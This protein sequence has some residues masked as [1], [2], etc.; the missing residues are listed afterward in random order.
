MR[1]I[2]SINSRFTRALVFSAGV[3]LAALAG[4]WSSQRPIKTKTAE[5]WQLHGAISLPNPPPA[6]DLLKQPLNKP[7]N[8]L[9]V[10]E[11]ADLIFRSLPPISNKKEPPS[12]PKEAAVHLAD[13]GFGPNEAA[14][15][16][17]PGPVRT[18]LIRDQQAFE[19]ITPAQENNATA[20]ALVPNPLS[21]AQRA[22][23]RRQFESLAEVGRDW[24]GKYLDHKATI[25]THD[26]LSFM[27]A[28]HYWF[29]RMQDKVYLMPDSRATL[30]DLR[31]E[32]ERWVKEFEPTA[33]DPKLSLDDKKQRLKG[34]IR[35]KAV[36]DPDAT[37]LVSTLREV[38]INGRRISINAGGQQCVTR[39][40]LAIGLILRFPNI[41]G[42]HNRLLFSRYGNDNNVVVNNPD[43]DDVAIYNTK[44]QQVL[45]GDYSTWMP[46]SAVR[47]NLLDPMY[48]V[49][50]LV[51][52]GSTS[53]FMF[54]ESEV[55]QGKNNAKAVVPGE[56]DPNPPFGG[57]ASRNT[58]YQGGKPVVLSRQTSFSDAGSLQPGSPAIWLGTA[59]SGRPGSAVKP[60]ALPHAVEGRALLQQLTTEAKRI[61]AQRFQ[62]EAEEKAAA[63]RL[64]KLD[65]VLTSEFSDR[66]KD[67]HWAL[68]HKWRVHFPLELCNLGL[69]G[70]AKSEVEDYIFRRYRSDPWQRLFAF[71]FFNRDAEGLLT[72]SPAASPSVDFLKRLYDTYQTPNNQW[73]GKP[74]ADYLTLDLS[75]ILPLQPERI[76][77]NLTN[78][79]KE[80][81]ELIDKAQAL[82]NDQ[83]I[84]QQLLIKFKEFSQLFFVPDS[85]FRLPPE[86]ALVL[87]KTMADNTAFYDRLRSG[88][89]ILEAVALD[90]AEPLNYD[91][92]LRHKDAVQRLEKIDWLPKEHKDAIRLVLAPTRSVDHSITPDTITYLFTAL[93]MDIGKVALLLDQE[94]GKHAKTSRAISQE[95][96][97]SMTAPATPENKRELLNKVKA[98]FAVQW[99]Y[100]KIIDLKDRVLN[101]NDNSSILQPLPGLNRAEFVPLANLIIESFDY[102][103]RLY[104]GY[105]EQLV[106]FGL[107]EQLDHGVVLIKEDAMLRLENIALED[108]N[109]KA[110]LQNFLGSA[111][112]YAFAGVASDIY[113]LLFQM[114]D[115][116]REDTFITLVINPWINELKRLANASPA[117]TQ[118]ITRQRTLLAKINR[119][120]VLVAS[121]NQGLFERVVNPH[122]FEALLTAYLRSYNREATQPALQDRQALAGDLTTLAALADTTVERGLKTVLNNYDEISFFPPKE[123]AEQTPASDLPQ[124]RSLGSDDHVFQ[125]N[126]SE[127][128]YFTIGIELVPPQEKKTSEEQPTPAK[129]R[130][131]VNRDS[132]IS[133]VLTFPWKGDKDANLPALKPVLNAL[134]AK[135]DDDSRAAVGDL[136]TNR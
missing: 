129:R 64:C 66:E 87:L 45:L 34:I 107:A 57:G 106:S 29:Q 77:S 4:I 41:L 80:L 91:V 135:L 83:R 6:E 127:G 136:L 104:F 119:G 65:V 35:S 52:R 24:V 81:V 38:T 130:L 105:A 30:P 131:V 25:T 120:R 78:F 21:P 110:E 99:E 73:R 111:E 112:T 12:L 62:S 44:T 14:T 53:E 125:V 28:S 85:D 98:L 17:R 69:S 94:S 23:A 118:A 117:D 71:G 59:P 39:A 86:K 134:I 51:G 54:H 126:S 5:H 124:V 50:A 114:R 123:K 3:H 42:P 10:K 43:H 82:P 48:Y 70:T 75:L 115:R 61:I 15:R 90:L 113:S 8:V 128:N 72:R 19:T 13:E 68:I 47:G 11:I 55:N 32:L 31:N 40:L 88:D 37:N 100:Q 63:K 101:S 20:P 18:I 102:Y 16:F 93:G 56:K 7:K 33:N 84:S 22:E 36:Y 95:I 58:F 97:R 26:F 79:Y 27:L 108:K 67:R 74:L 76:I 96:I 60:T 121:Q 89:Y 132:F 92:V 109:L 133:F 9:G 49:A 46:L 1:G 116:G 103:K 2:N 122:E